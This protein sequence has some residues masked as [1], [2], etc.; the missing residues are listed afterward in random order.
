MAAARDGG[1]EGLPG[2][3]D[4]EEPHRHRRRPHQRRCRPYGC[5]RERL[6]QGPDL[7]T[8]HHERGGGARCETEHPRLRRQCSGKLDQR[9]GTAQDRPPRARRL[10][11]RRG[12]DAEPLRQGNRGALHR[13]SLGRAA[14]G[15]HVRRADLHHR[16]DRQAP[17][18]R[19]PRGQGHRGERGRRE[20]RGRDGL[21]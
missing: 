1:T 2:R 3:S 4:R 20:P 18:D 7:E 19:R 15:R 9:R 12:D 13:P 10:H 21:R 17:G 6:H 11:A 16:R 14:D 5:R 8:R